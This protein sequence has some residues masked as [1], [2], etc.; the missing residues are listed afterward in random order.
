M[1]RVSP[2]RLA[3]GR[4]GS[5]N[6]A[7]SGQAGS[8][9]RCTPQSDRTWHPFGIPSLATVAHLSPVW[10]GFTSRRMLPPKAAQQMQ[11][12]FDRIENRLG[13]SSLD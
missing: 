6:S 11:L 2:N 5:R 12:R 1:I 8:G 9:R 13:A 7:A 10:P 4:G 3:A